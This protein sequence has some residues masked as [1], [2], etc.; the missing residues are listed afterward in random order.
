MAS[1][2]RLASINLK[3]CPSKEL[4]IETQSGD[5]WKNVFSDKSMTVV[6]VRLVNITLV[7]PLLCHMPPELV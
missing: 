1:S 7:T 3:S 2:V 5:A 6:Q 4:S